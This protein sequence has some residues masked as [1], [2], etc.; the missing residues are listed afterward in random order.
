MKKHLTPHGYNLDFTKLIDLYE[1]KDE[2]AINGVVNYLKSLPKENRKLR[3]IG[4]NEGV[5]MGYQKSIVN[6][7]ISDICKPAEVSE[8]ILRVEID[9]FKTGLNYYKD[10]INAG[11]TINYIGFGN[12][13]YADHKM[14][15][16]G[17]E[18]FFFGVN[19]VKNRVYSRNARQYAN[20]FV[21]FAKYCQDSGHIEMLDK[22]V[23]CSD[24][25]NVQH[26]RVWHNV[27]INELSGKYGYNTVDIHCYADLVKPEVYIN[28]LDT[29]L[30]SKAW[31]GLKVVSFEMNVN[32]H[33][34]RH[35]A[36]T[37]QEIEDADQLIKEKYYQTQLSKQVYQNL[38]KLLDK[39]NVEVKILHCLFHYCCY[40]YGWYGMLWIN[41]QTGEVSVQLD[42]LFE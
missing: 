3:F 7:F 12:E 40:Y 21:A 5:G 36:R 17:F 10:F 9:D 19:W 26:L 16:N 30:S 13:E 8:I 4:G 24:Y 28:N 33:D 37:P 27:L 34:F 20:K 41:R 23:W 25:K 14:Q 38:V 2:K 18:R 32:Y 1:D 39:H 31:K 22:L 11:I 6:W 15:M 29:V 42:Y 35:N